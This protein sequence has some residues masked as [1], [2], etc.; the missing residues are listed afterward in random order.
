[1]VDSKMTQIITD[2]LHTRIAKND[3]EVP[4]LP[5]VAS[6]VIRLTQ[7]KESDAEDL[8]RLIQSDQPLAGHVMRIANSALYSP[9][10]TLVSL[11]QAI[12]RLGMQIIADIA[13]AA[14]VNSKMF[15]A[16]GYNQ[17]IAEQLKF[18]L[19]CGVWAKEV[20][21]V[22]R[23]NVEA[24]F[25]AG[26][27]HDIGRPVAIQAA[28]EIA[29]GHHIKLEKSDVLDIALQ[30]DADLSIKVVRFW[31]MPSIVCDVVEHFH[32]YSAAGKAK[33]QTMISVAGS[34]F[35]AHF[36]KT[37]GHVQLNKKQLF[38]QPVFADLNLYQD[39]LD[40]LMERE[41][42]VKNTLEAMST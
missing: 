6:K 32:D 14:S 25:L 21:R 34:R 8:S 1:M 37:E 38:E 19:H 15:N 3:I 31:E 13:L 5:E 10:T 27:L 35:A 39:D 9:N 22:C 7:D 16:P 11:Q 20:A 23:R 42:Q 2:A 26:L 28:L 36:S 40:R 29:Q 33:E 12:A 17:F 18:S 24:A 4:L 41:A 30:F